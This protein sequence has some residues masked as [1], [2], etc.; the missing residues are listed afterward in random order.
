MKIIFILYNDIF[1]NTIDLLSLLFMHNINSSKNISI[2][3]CFENNADFMLLQYT[4]ISL[5][6]DLKINKVK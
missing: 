1:T 5:G 6:V 3:N 2:F 4:I